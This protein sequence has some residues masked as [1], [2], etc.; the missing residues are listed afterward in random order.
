MTDILKDCP[1]QPVARLLLAHG[2]GAAVQSPFMQ[3]LTAAL[4]QHKIEVWRFNFPYMQQQL[5]TGKKRPPDKIAILQQ[6]F[7][8]ILALCPS[9]LPL[10]C[11]GKSMGGRVASMVSVYPQLRAVF[12]YGYPFCPPGK[13]NWRT[14]HFEQLSCPLFIMQGERDPFGNKA[15]LA[16]KSWADVS[17][18]WLPGAD[19]DYKPLK[20]TGLTQQQLITQA[21]LFTSEKIN[22]IILANQ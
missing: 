8:Q 5:S 18:Q 16:E 15:Q 14:E 11:G 22:E 21:A 13:S 3:Q 7:M 4:L 17:L 10:F 12:A 20:K 1:A 19:H 2:A 9:D 6:Y